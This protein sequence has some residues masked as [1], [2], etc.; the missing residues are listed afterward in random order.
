MYSRNIWIL[1]G[2]ATIAWLAAPTGHAQVV[3]QAGLMPTAEAAALPHSGIL[4][5]AEFDQR[6]AQV[7]ERLDDVIDTWDFED[8]PFSAVREK[9][10]DT[11]GLQ[12]V[13]DHNA[14]LTWDT[15]VTCRLEN[16]SLRTA[17]ELVLS[18]HD[19]SFVV[20][21]GLLI[22]GR[23]EHTVET[24]VFAISDDLANATSAEELVELLK[25]STGEHRWGN[26]TALHIVGGALIARNGEPVLFELQHLLAALDA[27]R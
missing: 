6:S 18:P 23:T 15:P 19:T 11:T 2:V 27:P 24:R 9:I 5:F 25:K 1:W 26:L 7:L 10:F 17:L 22:L 4:P 14:D 3:I 13:L 8:E 21:D 20:R 16:V 12:L